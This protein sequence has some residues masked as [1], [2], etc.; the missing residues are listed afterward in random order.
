MA[1]EAKEANRLHTD[2][3]A[4]IRQHRQED[5]AQATA[6]AVAA[7]AERYKSA[8]AAAAQIN[9]Q[10]GLNAGIDVVITNDS[11]RT[12]RDLR[13]VELSGAHPGWRWTTNR[14]I[15]MGNSPS[16]PRLAAGAQ[17]KVACV[18]HDE[19]GVMQR[20]DGERYDSLVRFTDA[21]GQRWEI[22]D[23][24]GPRQV[25]AGDDTDLTAPAAPEPAPRRSPSHA[26]G[27]VQARA[28]GSGAARAPRR[29]AGP[30]RAR[31]GPR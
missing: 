19:Q 21:E 25:P 7:E 23:G 2:E 12:I 24:A 13:L 1:D 20:T 27:W 17:K 4:L 15:F 14:N 31:V 9:V 29:R 26:L 18:F 3:I 16:E 28:P 5:Q 11:P 22:G 10:Y 30:R 6:S 8:R